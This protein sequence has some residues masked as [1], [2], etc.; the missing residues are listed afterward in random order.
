MKRD[1]ASLFLAGVWR[2][3][4]A[5]NSQC[6]GED[7]IPI[8][9]LLKEVRALA[10]SIEK[11]FKVHSQAKREQWVT[12]HPSRSLRHVLNVDG[13]SVGNPSPA[14]FGGLLR[15]G[16]GKWLTGCYGSIGVSENLKAELAALFHGLLMAWDFGVR[17]LVCYSDSSFA[18]ELCKS[19]VNAHHAYAAL[20]RG[21]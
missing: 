11:S 14:S 16:D 6:L 20:I 17:D 19:P 12:W 1:T 2:A 5:R 8:F 9:K 18:I 4:C 21:I 3:W 7:P 13:S 10:I 15:T